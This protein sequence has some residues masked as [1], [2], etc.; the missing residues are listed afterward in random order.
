MGWG[1][2]NGI[3][4]TPGEP[5][6]PTLGIAGGT[7]PDTGRKVWPKSLASAGLVMSPATAT[8]RPYL[9]QWRAG[10][11]A[12]VRRGDGRDGA[13]LARDGMGIGMIAEKGAR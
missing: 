7:A 12:Q 4:C 3:T 11:V 1:T 2:G 6:R 8:F 13:D 10:E 5:R 9:A